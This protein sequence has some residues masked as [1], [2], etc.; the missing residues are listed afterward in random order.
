MNYEIYIILW[1]YEITEYSVNLRNACV[2]CYQ[3]RTQIRCYYD[4]DHLKRKKNQAINQNVYGTHTNG[5]R[6][7][8]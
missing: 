8:K 2:G 7:C 1:E 3:A 6:G 5:K 4:D